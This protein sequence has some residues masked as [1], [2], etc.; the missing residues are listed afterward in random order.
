MSCSNARHLDLRGYGDTWVHR[1]D[2]RI[3]VLLVLIYMGCVTSFPKYTVAALVP[4]FLLPVI[5]GVAGRIP[6][7]LLFRM[8]AAASPFALLVGAFNP[9]LDRAVL[10]LGP[11][12]LGA[13][14]FSFT[15]ILLRF[16]LTVSM[17]LVLTATTSW[18]GM[19]H[20]LTGL[21]VPRAFV[22]QL[23]LLFRYLF[24]LVEESDRLGHARQLRAPDRR[25]P[26]IKSAG[27]MLS[28]LLWRTWERSDRLY[29]ALKAR[30]FQG[31]FPRRRP[32]RITVA[33]AALL[34][35]GAGACLAARLLPLTDW[36]G[37]ALW[38]LFP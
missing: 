8:L 24:V 7:G 2:S 13:G 11:W 32:D 12:T 10:T 38:S 20:G 14:W 29:R 16:C 21:R 28:A 15:S 23:H 36:L 18:P 19:M 35:A 31:D 25:L 27:H 34:L 33:D 22:T 1:A 26:G 6:P 9:W 4:Y 5:L 30:G 17:L 37:Q 3:K